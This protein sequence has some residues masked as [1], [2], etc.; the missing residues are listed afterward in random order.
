[1][2]QGKGREGVGG[3]REDREREISIDFVKKRW[4]TRDV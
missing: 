3:G 4:F 1:M 2:G